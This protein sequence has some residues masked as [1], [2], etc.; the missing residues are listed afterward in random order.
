MSNDKITLTDRDVR[1]T[2]PNPG[3]AERLV[4]GVATAA[5]AVAQAYRAGARQIWVDIVDGGRLSP[6]AVDD[7][8][9]AGADAALHFVVDHEAR[10]KRA[11]DNGPITAAAVLEATGKASDGL[12]SRLFNRPVSRRISAAL[13][14]FP[15][16]RPWHA[17]IL[18]GLV[19]AAMV[20]SLLFGGYGGLVA[21]GLLFQTASLLD[22]VDGEIARATYRSSPRGALLDTTVDMAINIGFFAAVTVS[23]TNLY[24]HNQ[25]LAGGTAIVLVATGLS[26][27][28][29]LA[30]RLG[31]PGDF[32]FL[33]RFY[34]ERFPTGLAAK[35]TETLVVVTSR[36]FFALAFAVVIL[37]GWGQIILFALAGFAVLWLFLVLCAVRPILRDSTSMGTIGSGLAVDDATRLA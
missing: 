7:V 30:R 27:M 25:A 24:G 29:L 11:A 5:H 20:L 15:G 19:G 17:T 35:I 12:A 8:R 22:G 1:L 13:L 26:I 18:V 2:F 31:K 6:Q 37:L 21:G 34:Q 16:V 9:R 3:H 33:K 4:A 14:R 23:L 32:N 28:A 36:D 10:L